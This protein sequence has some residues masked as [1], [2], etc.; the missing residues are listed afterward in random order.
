MVRALL[1]DE[2]PAWIVRLEAGPNEKPVSEQLL[3][4][5]REVDE[6]FARAMPAISIMRAAA[7]CQSS[8]FKSFPGGPPPVRAHAALV[9]FFK[10]LDAQ[11]RARAPHP[12][13]LAS[14]FLGAVHGRHTLRHALGDL[15]PSSG[16]NYA[17][18]LVDLFWSGIRPHTEDAQ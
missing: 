4:V 16:D 15:A 11:G 18:V 6:F 9:E 3:D 12:E 14:A 13:G 8:I 7:I 10:Q 5:V 1:P 2:Q 17:E